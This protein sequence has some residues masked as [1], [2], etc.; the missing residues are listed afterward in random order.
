MPNSFYDVL[1]VDHNATLDEIKL[2]FKRQALQV[3][4]D[5]GGSKE[6]FHLVYQ[7]LETLS[8]PETRRNY[9]H[10]LAV[11]PSPRQAAQNRQRRAKKHSHKAAKPSRPPAGT[12]PS[13]A[14]N[15]GQ[16][17]GKLL[18]KIHHLLK[19]LPRE[20]RSTVI[21]RDFSQ[22]QRL[23]LEKWMAIADRDGKDVRNLWDE[24]DG[25]ACNA[26]ALLPHA[27]SFS[28]VVTSGT[29]LKQKGSS[30]KR[31]AKG[32]SVRGMVGCVQRIRSSYR[33]CICFDAIEIHTAQCDL[34]T[35][36]EY[37]VILTAVKQKVLQC[38]Q[39]GVEE[40]LQ[41]ALISSAREHGRDAAALGLRFAVFQ[42]AGIFIGSDSQVRSPCVRD[43]KDFAKIRRCLEPFRAYAKNTWKG[44]SIYWF[45]SPANLQDA[46][47]RFQRAVS[48][49]WKAAG[50][51]SAPF[52]QKIQTLYKANAS[53]REKHLQSWER[54][55]MAMQDE[56]KHRPRRLRAGSG[57]AKIS[58]ERRHMAMNDQNKH[59]PRRFRNQRQK[60]EKKDSLTDKLLVLNKLLM[61]WDCLF[62]KEAFLVEKAQKKE[63]K[64]TQQLDA[65]KKRQLQEEERLK[66]ES[67]RKKMRSDRT[68]DDILGKKAAA[69]GAGAPPPVTCWEV[70]AEV[71]NAQMT[72]HLVQV[73]PAHH[74]KEASAMELA[75]AG[76]EAMGAAL[77]QMLGLSK[78]SEPPK[79]L[80]QL[81]M[82]S[83]RSERP[84][85]ALQASALES[86]ASVGWPGASMKVRQARVE[87]L[88]RKFELEKHKQEIVA[89]EMDNIE[90]AHVE[91][92]RQIHRFSLRERL[93]QNRAAKDE[94]EARGHELWQDNMK[95]RMARETEQMRFSDK[96]FRTQQEKEQHQRRFAATEVL[97][98]TKDFEAGLQNLG[99]TKAIEEGMPEDSSGEDDDATAER[100]LAQTSKVA[101]A[102]ELVDALQAKLP[103]NQELNYEAGLFMRKIKESKQAGTIARR[104]RER[105]RRR[106]LVEQQR[107]QEML[108]EN[109]LE[110]VLM[111]KLNRESIEESAISY[112]SWRAKT[113]EEV[114]VRNRQ[115]RQQQYIAKKKADKEEALKWDQ[116]LRDEMIE[117]LREQ[118]ERERIR[119]R[120]VERFRHA[121][122]REKLREEM[123]GILELIVQMAFADLQQEQLTDKEEVDST[124][125]REWVALFEENLP[126]MPLPSLQ[127]CA[128]EAAPLTALPEPT[129]LANLHS[130][131]AT[132]NSAALRD[133][134]DARGQ[135]QVPMIEG[136]DEE[137][138][139]EV[140]ASQPTVEAFNA[141][142]EVAA[143]LE[144]A[145]GVRSPRGA[146][147]VGKEVL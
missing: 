22:K 21:R 1:L 37:L 10:S 132:L 138:Q 134:M 72:V 142:A 135:W 98:G 23:I 62:Q 104:E 75:M 84:A 73:L 67:I 13:G 110:Q 87:K 53:F 143:T 96:V 128:E 147:R 81:K 97:Q 125:W 116:D 43:V 44:G 123:E 45:H 26:L 4:P 102:K 90:Q 137:L 47:E 30:K 58:W 36:L 92:Q 114:F 100:L 34:P 32:S 108:E 79:L 68:M 12:A 39:T 42:R 127:M 145:Q 28:P 131:G 50:V 122:R 120:A 65:L 126:V 60:H 27:S 16:V 17:Q 24:K 66:R 18:V 69:L 11:R 56:N 55:H 20:L 82:A 9:D 101:S 46:W 14:C 59:K 15:F 78:A 139:E 35:A 130:V 129:G 54:Q 71:V 94:W 144:E 48:E 140:P 25:G 121:K 93:R 31:A 70:A 124:L 74:E 141:D 136:D 64:A 133:F 109:Q 52:I 118:E 111:E 95:V 51:D 115:A 85:L 3:H 117:T 77:K 63:Q 57:A 76:A 40:R 103:T 86:Q 105:R 6:A 33:A 7:A 41:Q 19:E 38:T 106:V 80:Y 49:A 5:K 89:F 113:F 99:I 2:A 112:R 119:Y 61:K 8:D 146:M 107:E 83:E 88:T 91:E 29:P